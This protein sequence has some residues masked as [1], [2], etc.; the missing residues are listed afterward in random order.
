MV[1]VIIMMMVIRIYLRRYRY[2]KKFIA[3]VIRHEYE[4]SCAS[5]TATNMQPFTTGWRLQLLARFGSG[6]G[7]R[8]GA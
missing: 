8:L 6:D 7:A 2:A 3:R 1:A 5:A 4:C